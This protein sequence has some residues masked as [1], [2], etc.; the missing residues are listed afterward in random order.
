MIG[1]S[2]ISPAPL[3]LLPPSEGKSSGGEGPPLDMNTLSFDAL[4]PTRDRIA[5]ALVK[6][7]E[8]PRSS[9]SLLG[10]KGVALEK[11]MTENAELNSTPTQPAIERYTGV[12]YDAINHQSLDT[13]ARDT[14]GQNVIIISGLFGMVRPFDMIPAYKLKMGAK[15][16]RKKTCAAIWKPLITKSLAVMDLGENGVIWDLLPIEHSA[17]WDPSAVP[18]KN[19]FTVKFLERNAAGELR[20]VNH[21]SKL[22]KGSL[23]R[24]LVSNPDASGS[25]ESALDLIAD[26]SHP[27]GHK[28]DPALTSETDGLTEIVF[29][30]N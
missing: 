1:F 7:S 22:L 3:I 17:A 4:N 9:R 6:L 14:F 25:T 24:H 13:A 12:M 23:I 5:T 18:H 21:W 19:R 2:T 28:F 16:I 20:T 11:A 29:V 26:F 10:V 30:K 8:R 15:L 27:E